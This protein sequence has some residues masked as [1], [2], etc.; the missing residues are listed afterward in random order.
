MRIFG[1]EQYKELSRKTPSGFAQT[2]NFR[3]YS[4]D[5][6]KILSHHLESGFLTGRWWHG[7]AVLLLTGISALAVFTSTAATLPNGYTEALI[8]DGMPFPTSMAFAPDGRLF[9]CQQAGQLR[10]IKD[11]ALL[12]TP[13]LAVTVDNQGERGLL[14]VAFDPNFAVNQYVYVYYTATTPTVHNRVSRFT[15][16]GDVAMAGSEVILLDLNDLSGASNHNG[17]ALHFGSDGKLYIGVGENAN[18]SNSQTLANLLGKVLR[19]N[20]D[21]TI[22]TNNPFYTATT[23]VNRA[24]WALGL[25]NPFSFAVQPGTGRMFI[26][27]VG[28][29]TWEEINEGIAGANYGWP[30]CEGDCDPADSAFR[31]PLFRYNH[32]SGSS[33]GN[34]IAGGD[35][36]NPTTSN[37]PASAAGTYFFA[38]YVNGWIHQMD[39]ANGNQVSSFATGIN[40]P[41]D[42]KVGPDGRLY[43]LTYQDDAVFAISYTGSQSPQITQQPEDQTVAVGEAATLAVAASGT[44]QLSYQ[45]WC[46]GTNIADATASS[47]TLNS[48]GLADNGTAFY[49]VVANDYGATTSRLAVVYVE[50]NALPTGSIVTPAA[51][52][53]Y[54]AGETIPFSG[55]ATDPEDGP[56]PASAFSWTI[57]FHHD[58]HTHPFLGPIAGVTNGSFV[59]PT[60]GETSAHVWYRIHLTVTD[61]AGQTQTSFRDILPNTA[62][63]SLTTS[64]PGLQLTLDGQPLTTP[65][66]ITN[67]VG[68]SRTLGVVTPQAQ[69]GTNYQFVSWSDDGSAIHTINAPPTDTN[70]TAAFQ[71]VPPPLTLTNTNLPDATEG[72]TY[73]ATL[74]ATGGTL[75]HTWSV[76]DGS[77]PAGLTLD[78]ASGA[79]N[80]TP[81]TT[82]TF[83]FTAQ[84]TD[85]GSPAQ[86]LTQP[87]SL[88]VVAP[89][90]VLS[91]FVGNTNSGTFTDGIGAGWINLVQF[92]ASADLRVTNL[93]AQ[94][95]AISGSYQC[96]LY[97]DNAGQPDRLLAA[98][99]V[100]SNPG[101]GWQTFALLQ[102]ASVTNG[103]AYWLA[104]AS[105]DAE[106]RVYYSDSAGTLRW[107]QYPYGNWPDPIVAPASGT[108]NYCIY[109][110]GTVISNSIAETPTATLAV[111]N[112]PV[113]YDGTAQAATV[114][115]TVS[116]VPGAVANVLTGGTADKTAAGSYAVT[117]D[118]VPTDTANYQ[119]LVGVAVGNFVISKAPLTITGL[120][121]NAKVY[122][123][124]TTAVVAGTAILNGVLSPDVVTVDASAA[125][126]NFASKDVGSHAVTLAGYALGGADK[127]NYTLSAQPAV[128]DA[129]I[130]PVT[131]VVTA[132]DQSRAYGQ[133]NPTLTASYAGFVN[134]ETLATS[135]VTGV[136]DLNTAATTTS[137]AGSYPITAALGSLSAVNYDF[138][139]ADGT[140]TVV[141]EA[142]S[143]KSVT[144]LDPTHVVIYWNAISNVT[145]R[146]QYRPDLDTDWADLVPDVTA[147][148]NTALAVDNLADARQ[149]FYRI[150]VVP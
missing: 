55:T 82:G 67:V 147:T 22:P 66:A 45:W 101:T 33:E 44:P 37:F 85:A 24:I 149:R 71:L 81:M 41:V 69:N 83:N 31:D 34:C 29:S 57:V 6:V 113:T 105:D 3:Q 60:Q 27:D 8:A 115:I 143:I 63:M 148:S 125:T 99:A 78:P 126:A 56:L 79:I 46:D 38:D 140:L 70:Y 76:A 73:A 2:S 135:G 53:F 118:F 102:P 90:S 144:V 61:S 100:V 131:L 43:Y 74:T 17:G 119:S 25:R 21:G 7:A 49:C 28:E 108:A 95:V 50:N 14:G 58:V 103:L 142:P 106:A 104:I 59:I 16:N 1:F 116:S 127:D 137:P 51:G 111:N 65:A 26:N 47:Y 4:Y 30:N 88:L 122:D 87:L 18:S 150:L 62:V 10:V 128:A 40:A 141:G 12:A 129:S 32:G 48:P 64:P 93:Y 145:Y 54:N 89:P 91:G 35:F 5:Q 68:F 42:L 146:V 9:V 86:S 80:G 84:V 117:A 75:P 132:N 96:A 139:F 97:T 23:G 11:G 39:P 20:A 19:I 109:A 123:G 15:A 107:G 136:P 112:T 52:T 94:V 138:S 114:E 36:Y 134:G 98:T 13:F 92:Q 130:T 77:L 110:A 124:N 72:V 133:G 120:S 121:A